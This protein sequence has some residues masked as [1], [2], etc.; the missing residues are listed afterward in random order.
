MVYQIRRRGILKN[1]RGKRYFGYKIYGR[2]G[3]RYSR[4]RR[5]YS[6]MSR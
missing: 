6:I 2:K 1:I 3:M 4:N 5:I